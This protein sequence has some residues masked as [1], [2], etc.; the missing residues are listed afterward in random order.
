MYFSVFLISMLYHRNTNSNS[1]NS[2]INTN[3]NTILYSVREG[4]RQDISNAEV[5]R[6]KIESQETDTFNLD[7]S[8]MGEVIDRVV[9]NRL[10]DVLATP[11]LL[12]PFGYPAIRQ[13]L[14]NFV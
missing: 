2:N 6:L 14:R 13:R 3:I 12:D 4:L 8:S 7:M 10:D 11:N 5:V 9:V 1:T